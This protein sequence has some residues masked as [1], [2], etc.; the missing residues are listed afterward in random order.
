MR[1]VKLVNREKLTGTGYLSE[2]RLMQAGWNELPENKK[3]GLTDKD[4]SWDFMRV[5]FPFC[6]EPDGSIAEIVMASDELVFI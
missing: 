1:E 6:T 5:T 4:N 3:F 2:F